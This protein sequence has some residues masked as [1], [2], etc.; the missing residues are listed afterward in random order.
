METDPEFFSRADAH[1][2]LS[3]SQIQADIGPGKVSASLLYSA[4]RFNA[5]VTATGYSSGDEMKAQKEEVI[6]YFAT[7]YIKMLEENLDEYIEN[8][9]E[10]MEV[11]R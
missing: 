11:Q 9:D 7:E 3:N 6:D 1:I 2:N 5:W 10:H 8:F 4:A